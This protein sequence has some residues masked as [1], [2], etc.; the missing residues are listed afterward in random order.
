[1]IEKIRVGLSDET[2]EEITVDD[3]FFDRH[4]RAF[5]GT[6]LL[7]QI[8]EK[9]GSPPGE[10]SIVSIILCEEQPTDRVNGNAVGQQSRYPPTLH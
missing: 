9:R 3:D 4:T 6:F 2:F 8:A 10:L 7:G 5:A 1:M